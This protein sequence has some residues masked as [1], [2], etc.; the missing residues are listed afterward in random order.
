MNTT[1]NK[2]PRINRHDLIKQINHFLNTTD[3]DT[4]NIIKTYLGGWVHFT[5]HQPKQ[6][7]HDSGL[8]L[9][10]LVRLYNT[11]IKMQPR[12]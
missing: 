3:P 8:E 5:P 4:I 9:V 2:R 10:T 12:A 1:N 7:K 11:L 6:I